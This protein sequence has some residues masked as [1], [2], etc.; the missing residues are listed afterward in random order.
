MNE[1]Q[2]AA[3]PDLSPPKLR[4]KLT[5]PSQSAAPNT[6]QPAPNRSEHQSTQQTLLLRS[7]HVENP[8]LRQ[9]QR[10]NGV[11]AAYQTVP[12]HSTF[13]IQAKSSAGDVSDHHDV[14]ERDS[15]PFK[16]STH[17]SE[18]ERRVSIYDNED[19]YQ[20]ESQKL[21]IRGQANKDL[22]HSQFPA[23]RGL[24]QS[25]SLWQASREPQGGNLRSEHTPTRY[26]PSSH[27][28][29]EAGAGERHNAVKHRQIPTI[30]AE[31]KEGS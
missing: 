19:V 28:K 21:R 14:S 25:A 1:I 23:P 10:L 16:Y 17:Q 5:N 13:Q 2:N 29:D 7:D 12:Q 3:S 11:D 15:S 9:T 6:I 24:V 31:S 30:S 18:Q 20:Q 27:Y 26:G 8:T 22:H 4:A